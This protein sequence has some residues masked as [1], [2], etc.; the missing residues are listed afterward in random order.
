MR[1]TLAI[2]SLAL[3][4]NAM[5]SISATGLQCVQI[6]PPVTANFPPLFSLNAEAWDELQG[7]M[8][9]NVFCDMTVNPSNSGGPT[10]GLVSGLVDSH[11]IHFTHGSVPFVSG[12][13]WFNDPIVGVMFNDAPLDLSD[14]LGAGGTLYPTGQIARGTNLAFGSNIAINGNYMHFSLVDINPAIAISQIRV[15]TRPVP[16]PGAIGL[17]ALGGLVAFRRRR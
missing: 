5:G 12:D 13:I 15:L 3:A 14:W 4:A 6:S 10:P 8:V 7:V 16:A 1:T 11:F 17:A 9:A 2:A